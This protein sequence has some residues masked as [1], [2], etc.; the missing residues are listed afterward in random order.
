[1]EGVDSAVTI[2]RDAG[3][4]GLLLY[5]LVT[6]WNE[7]KLRDK[8]VS[9]LNQQLIDVVKENSATHATLREAVNNNTRVIERIDN[10]IRDTR[11][12]S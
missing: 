9:E 12:D 2:L 8:K 5:F 11:G 1:M 3:L 10:F 6:V 7:V 4:A